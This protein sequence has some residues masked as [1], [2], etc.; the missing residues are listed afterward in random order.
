MHQ[1]KAERVKRDKAQAKS[2]AA[3]GD[4]ADPQAEPDSLVP[5]SRFQGSRLASGPSPSPYQNSIKTHYRAQKV[6]RL[7]SGSSVG[8]AIVEAESNLERDIVDNNE[9]LKTKLKEILREKSDAF[10]SEQP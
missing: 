10:N 3:R 7:S 4:D 5:V 9:E 1:R 8:A 2:L 6:A